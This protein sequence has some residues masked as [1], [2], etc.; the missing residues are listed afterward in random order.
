MNI[1]SGKQKQ[2]AEYYKKQEKLLEGFNEVDA[3]T[4]LG[5]LP[6]SLTEVWAFNRYFMEADDFFLTFSFVSN[7]FSE[8]LTNKEANRFYFLSHVQIILHRKC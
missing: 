5:V 6:G 1:C 7:K 3:F 2:V 4:E 8:G